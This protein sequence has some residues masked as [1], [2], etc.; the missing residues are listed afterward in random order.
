MR[1]AGPY[2]ALHLRY[3]KDM[4]AFSGCTYGLTDDEAEELTI[5]RYQISLIITFMKLPSLNSQ[6]DLK[7]N[8]YITPMTGFCKYLQPIKYKCAVKT[9]LIGG[10]RK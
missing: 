3:E 8:I 4:L 10:S 5:I 6:A 1:S 7:A 9:H 2:I